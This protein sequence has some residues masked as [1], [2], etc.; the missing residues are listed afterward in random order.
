MVMCRQ[1]SIGAT[2]TTLG[3]VWPG[4]PRQTE[5]WNKDC[6]KQSFF[7]V[8]HLLY[9]D[10]GDS[11][12]S[13]NLFCRQFSI[14]PHLPFQRAC[15][16]NRTSE[17]ILYV[18]MG[19]VFRLEVQ[20][21][22]AVLIENSPGCVA[23]DGIFGFVYSGEDVIQEFQFLGRETRLGEKGPRNRRWNE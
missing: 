11:E 13:G 16:A 3:T 21:G 23:N 9:S 12:A 14:C 4:I 17:L 15:L 20:V 5:H 10:P 7:Q 2:V 19:L 8:K 22:A 18:K 6:D 1:L